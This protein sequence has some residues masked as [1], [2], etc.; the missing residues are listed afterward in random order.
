MPIIM[1]NP[2][3]EQL[4]KLI[5]SSEHK[6]EKWVCQEG[7]FWYCRPEDFTHAKLA[8]IVRFAEFEKGIAV[9]SAASN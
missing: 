3:P 8:S 2:S 1:H 9:T 4:S 6:A 5:E 7:H